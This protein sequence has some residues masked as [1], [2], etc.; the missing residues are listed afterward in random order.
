MTA[1]TSETRPV[2]RDRRAR[3]GFAAVAYAFGVVMLGNTLPTPLYSIYQQ[4]YGFGSLLT[5]VIY[6]VYAVGVIAALL[7]LGKASDVYGRRRL[8]LAG[9]AASVASGVLFL[10]DA[11]LPALFLGRVLSGVSAGIFTTTATVA[12]LDLAPAR[13]QRRAA[14]VATAVNMLG[15]GCGPLLA[16]LL[17]RYTAAPLAWPFVANLALLVPAV[18]GVL[19]MP[20]PVRL[21]PGARFRP[22]RPVVAAEAR[23]VFVPAAVAVFAAFA[24][25]GLLTAV[26]P[27]FLATVLGMP[28]RA[29]A[30]LVVFTMFAGSAAGQVGLA[31]VPTRVALP[32]GSLV[33][34]LGLAGIAVGLVGRLFVPMLVGTVVIGVGQALSFRSGIAAITA[35]A[36]EPTRAGTVASFFVVA[37][38]GISIPVIAVGVAATAYGLRTAGIAFTAVVAF[39]ALAACV[40]VLRLDRR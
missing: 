31:R 28:D 30:G 24:V 14:L 10:T 27:G 18:L 26:E 35:A 38:V 5:T 40:A 4:R 33:L 29:L 3:F 37:Y 25:F 1:H 9:L 23:S 22:Q 34:V 13:L 12:L 6:A 19:R 11:G 7:L 8:L 36:P 21:V 17:A 20:E 32:A 16:G 39:V 2:V 15:L